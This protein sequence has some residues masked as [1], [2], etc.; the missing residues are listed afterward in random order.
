M[1]LKK[2]H[3]LRQHLLKN[4]L[5]DKQNWLQKIDESEVEHNAIVK[6]ISDKVPSRS[7]S[8]D[9]LMIFEKDMNFAS[10]NCLLRRSFSVNVFDLRRVKPLDV[11]HLDE[12]D[13]YQRRDSII[14]NNPEPDFIANFPYEER[15][16][17][18]HEEIKEDNNEQEIKYMLLNVQITSMKGPNNMESKP[19]RVRSKMQVTP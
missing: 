18:V 10:I 13:S 12:N 2:D 17:E 14:K 15:K 7:E 1:Y 9:S 6:H 5:N 16:Q 3:L 19:P 8:E 11:N 4:L